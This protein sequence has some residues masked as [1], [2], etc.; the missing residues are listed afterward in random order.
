M[1]ILFLQK[2][3]GFRVQISGEKTTFNLKA[4]S[5]ML[6]LSLESTKKFFACRKK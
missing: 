4:V 1:L 2:K 5:Q 3:W 6:K